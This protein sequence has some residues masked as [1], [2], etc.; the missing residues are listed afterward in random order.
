MA[1]TLLTIKII[2]ILIMMP[3]LFIIKQVIR[4]MNF[5]DLELFIY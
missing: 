4:R 1:M 3:N 5:I 2:L